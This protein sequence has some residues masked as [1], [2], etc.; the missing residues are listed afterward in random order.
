MSAASVS[1]SAGGAAEAAPSPAEIGVVVRLDDLSGA[2]PQCWEMRDPSVIGRAERIEDVLPSLR[3]AQRRCNDAGEWVAFV[4]AYEAAPAFDGAFRTKSRPPAGTPFVWWAS[5]AERTAAAPLAAIASRVT[6]R[7]RVRSSVP[8]QQA[9]Q[10]IRDRI[11][12]GDVYQVNMT[13]RFVGTYDGDAFD[14]YR[15][16]IGVQACSHGAYVDMGT[17]VVA[18]ASPEL[19]FRVD[20]RTITC[21]PMK[22]TAARHPRPA[23]DAAVATALLASEKDRAENVMIVDLLRN[24]LSRIAELGSVQVPRLF[25]L[26][27]YET[28]W[29]M[30]STVTAQIAPALQ[31]VDL[32]AALFPCG[33]ITGAPKVAAMAIIDELED[34][35]RGVYCGAIGLLAP[36]GQ[37]PRMQC[38]VPIRTAVA[39]PSARTFTYGAGGGITWLSQAQAED[40]EVRA[41]ARILTRSRRTFDLFETLRHTSAGPLH[42][43]LHLDRLADSA[44]WFGFPFDRRAVAAALARLERPVA[45]ERLRLVLQAAGSFHLEQ[46]PLVETRLPVVLAIDDVVS[47]SDDPF[48]CHKTTFRRHYE[49]ARK[50]HPDTDDVVLV[51]ELGNAVETTIANL[52]YRI[53]DEWF[54]PPLAD[55]GLAGIARHCAITEG[56]VTE[57]SISAAALRECHELAVVNDLRGWRVAV[58]VDQRVPSASRIF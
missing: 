3:A 57:R 50:R 6:H 43:D 33:S 13:E 9:V 23:D 8:Y 12:L 10:Q 47:P 4:V 26:E 38:S 36:R 44:A 11:E 7:E 22:G 20:D 58:L 25:E 35:P 55:G 51:N 45:D 31:L 17:A 5:F 27:R 30:T 14:L 49:D 39:A 52:A 40:D 19:F 48:S 53:H 32:L 21:R 42:A 18:S 16:L 46:H 2:V 24:D 15:G 29:Q 28:V 41:K 34:E 37:Q 54:V 56:T 1:R